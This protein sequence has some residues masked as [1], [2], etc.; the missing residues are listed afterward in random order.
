MNRSGISSSSSNKEQGSRELR[1][2][3]D[4]VMR[5]DEQTALLISPD[6]LFAGRI[7]AA[8]EPLG[9][10]LLQE[11]DLAEIDNRL[12][13]G[14][15]AIVLFDLNIASPTIGEVMER[16]PGSQRPLTVA[17]GPHVNTVRLQEAKDAGCDR[18]L[19]RSRF[20]QELPGLLRSARD[21]HS[22]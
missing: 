6:L 5:N 10:R 20:V 21:S 16:L 1:T 4:R 11:T 12:S 8:A 18:V 14:S 19:P 22:E 9:M 2:E 3:S 17:F 13:E 15:V 7:Q